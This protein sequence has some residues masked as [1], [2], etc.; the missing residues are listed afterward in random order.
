MGNLAVRFPNRELFW[1]GEAMEVTNDRTPTPTSGASTG[2][3]GV[4]RASAEGSLAHRVAKACAGDRDVE[5]R[6]QL[7]ESRVREPQLGVACLE[8]ADRAL[9]IRQ[10]GDPR[11]FLGRRQR[12]Q[13]DA[14]PHLRFGRVRERR[15]HLEGDARVGATEALAGHVLQ[16]LHLGRPRTV[17]QGL[18]RVQ[19]NARPSW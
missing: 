9:A 7:G 15:T 3:A 4:C 13:S 6:A 10:A 12:T 5:P 1:N 11:L 16:G 14:H 17:P 8:R 2:K 19:L 18:G